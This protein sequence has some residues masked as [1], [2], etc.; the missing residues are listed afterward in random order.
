[1]FMLSCIDTAIVLSMFMLSC[2]DTSTI[3]VSMHARS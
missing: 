3:S 2:F 1:M